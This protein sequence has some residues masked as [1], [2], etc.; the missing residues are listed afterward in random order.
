MFCVD[1]A[2]VADTQ[3]QYP[4]I[5]EKCLSKWLGF[6]DDE[7]AVFGTSQDAIIDFSADLE[8]QNAV[9]EAF[10]VRTFPSC[11]CLSSGDIR[12]SARVARL[13]YVNL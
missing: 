13:W 12:P 8:K 4:E 9:V 2:D 10:K 6:S 5:L 3:V 7:T 11:R 1:R